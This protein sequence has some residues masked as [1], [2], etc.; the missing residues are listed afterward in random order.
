MSSDVCL[1]RI[2]IAL[3]GLGQPLNTCASVVGEEACFAQPECD[4]TRLGHVARKLKERVHVNGAS[5][6]ENL[7]AKLLGSCVNEWRRVVVVVA[8]IMGPRHAQLDP[9]R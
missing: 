6:K 5:S 2:L 1:E 9:W 3:P 4:D 8:L 7:T